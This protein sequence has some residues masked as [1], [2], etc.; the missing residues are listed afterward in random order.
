MTARLIRL[1]SVS[2]LTGASAATLAIQFVY[3]LLLA[4]YFGT[5]A[6]MDAYG[7]ALTPSTVVSGLLIGSVGYAF[8]PQFVEISRREG[9]AAA[10]RLAASVGWSLAIFLAI[11]SAC[12][13]LAASGLIAA[14]YPGFSAAEVEL[15]ARLFRWL[16]W[17]AL[18]NSLIGFLQSLHHARQS[19]ATPALASIAGVSFTL[20]WAWLR[21]PSGGIGAVAEGVVYGSLVSIAIQ[22]PL[23]LK[24]SPW[25]VAWNRPLVRTIALAAPLLVGGAFKFEPQLDRYL[26]SGMGTGAIAQ[27][28]YSKALVQA[29]LLLTVSSLSTVLF[30]VVAGLAGE[31]RYDELRRELER[32]LQ[33]LAL[34]LVP[35][36]IGLL[37]LGRPL[38]AALLQRGEFTAADSAAVAQLLILQ[39]GILVGGSVGEILAKVFYALGDT[40]TPVTIGLAGLALGVGL[41]FLWYQP[42]GAAGLV[43]ATSMYL[44]AN[45][46]AMGFVLSRRT[47]P[48]VARRLLLTLARS[49][50]AGAAAGLAAWALWPRLGSWGVA[51]ASLIGAAV[52]LAVLAL[53]REPLAMELRQFASLWRGAD[54]IPPGNDL[55]AADPTGESAPHAAGEALSDGRPLG[56]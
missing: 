26:A 41:K 28:G 35:L 55:L 53:L 51:W 13:A 6:E 23:F 11:V 9:E 20:I 10:W 44:V 21:A 16:A 7:A 1:R 38:V 45:S 50:I 5:S 17:L 56:A 24:H 33:W 8:L 18:F 4:R 15:A 31:R 27:L 40:R 48:F 47:G 22:A 49:L 12:A 19:F 42:F 34:L 32:S 43:S 29:F 39:I 37:A 25:R 52:Y 2:L 14:L 30:P 46:A 54:T 36:A 3:Q